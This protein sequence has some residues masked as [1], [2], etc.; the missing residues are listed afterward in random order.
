MKTKGPPTLRALL[1]VKLRGP[2]V[3]F[4]LVF[5]GGVCGY[6]IIEGWPWLDSLWMVI[7]TLTTIGYS[8]THSLSDVGRVFTMVL[9]VSGV[10]LYAY[11]VGQLTRYVVDGELARSLA[12]RRK[13]RLMQNLRGHFIVVGLGRLGKEV[14]E[15][16]SHRGHQVVAIETAPPQPEEQ[17]YLA[18]RLHGDGSSDEMLREAAIERAAGVA[19]ATGSDAANIF[20]TLSARQMNP[21]IHIVTRVDEQESVQKALRAGANAVINPYGISGA[22]MAQG[23]THPQAA[24]L[25]DKAVGRGHAEFEIGDIPIG[26]APAYNGE[27]GDLKIPERHNI[28]LVALRKANGELLTSLGRATLVEPGDIAI[29]VGRPANIRALAKAAMS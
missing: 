18:L 26:V 3:V 27:L 29:V 16:L 13:R 20:I 8:E 28:Q 21:D 4:G 2:I 5:V 19:A 17:D 10:G 14:A 24:Q 23:L 6:R 1:L 9:I 11:T 15:E 25:L 22:R 7:I 12:E